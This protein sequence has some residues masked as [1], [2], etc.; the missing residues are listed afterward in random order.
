MHQVIILFNGIA[1]ASILSWS[2]D[3]KW[4]DWKYRIQFLN[5]LVEESIES[6]SVV[7]GYDCYHILQEKYYII[8]VML[9]EIFAQIFSF[10][11]KK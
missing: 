6:G 2:T 1:T 11:K 5:S 4:N 9:S 8:L 10:L 3:I 7:L